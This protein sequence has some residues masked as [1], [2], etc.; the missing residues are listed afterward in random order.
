MD[1][2][3]VVRFFHL[4]AMAF[5]VGGQLVLSFAVVPAVRLLGCARRWRRRRR[6]LCVQCGYDL[7]ASP[8][9]C[10]EC[11]L[12]VPPIRRR[13]RRVL[14]P[15]T[16]PVWWRYEAVVVVPRPRPHGAVVFRT[17]PRPIA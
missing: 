2:W 1:G 17:R 15:L 3:S 13:P 14:A 16:T 7:R 5:F 11:G 9:R 6:G 4:L 8:E 12:G 10:P